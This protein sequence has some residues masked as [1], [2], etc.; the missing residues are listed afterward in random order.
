MSLPKTSKRFNIYFFNKTKYHYIFEKINKII[1]TK[2]LQI[3]KKSKK[4]KSGHGQVTLK[5]LG[6]DALTSFYHIWGWL[7]NP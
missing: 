4:E 1:I 2:K 6:D 3:K 7:G 5:W